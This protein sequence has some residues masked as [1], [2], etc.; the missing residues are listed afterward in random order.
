MYLLYLKLDSARIKRDRASLQ[1]VHFLFLQCMAAPISGNQWLASQ[2][3]SDVHCETQTEISL[4]GLTR[5]LSLMLASENA[6]QK[7]KTVTLQTT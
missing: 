7:M 2:G 5:L 4:D 6:F 3:Q 1:L